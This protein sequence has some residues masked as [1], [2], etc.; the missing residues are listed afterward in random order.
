[1][2]GRAKLFAVIAAQLLVFAS[3][4]GYHEHLRR[5]APTFRIPLQP[6]DPFDLVRGRYFILNP[7]DSRVE[8]P[9]PRTDQD[10]LFDAFVAA[11]NGDLH[12]TGDLVVGFCPEAGPYGEVERLCTVRRPEAPGSA[13]PEPA[14]E[15]TARVR[16]WLRPPRREISDAGPSLPTPETLEGSIDFELDRFFVPNR[17]TLPPA[18]QRGWELEVIYRPGQ[19]L[20]PK[21]LWFRGEPLTL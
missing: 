2:S 7:Q 14:H 11:T 9:R 8:R 5:T 17:T 10:P 21:R 6:V 1:M 3:W 20:L 18:G 15:I 12:F 13:N 4:V 19:P 16:L